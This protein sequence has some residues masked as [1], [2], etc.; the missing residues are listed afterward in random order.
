MLAAMFHW[1]V[2]MINGIRKGGGLQEP[3]PCMMKECI[4]FRYRVC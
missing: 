4:R 3:E 1:N 2:G